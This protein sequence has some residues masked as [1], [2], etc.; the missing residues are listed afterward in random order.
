MVN[1]NRWYYFKVFKDCLSQFYFVHSWIHCLIYKEMV[2]VIVHLK[3]SK[4]PGMRQWCSLLNYS[5][6][7]IKALTL[8]GGNFIIFTSPW[9]QILPRNSI[10]VARYFDRFSQ[11]LSQRFDFFFYLGFFSWTFTIHSAAEV[12]ED[13]SNYILPFPPASQLLRD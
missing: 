9:Q 3:L 10:C 12:G 6:R 11:D 1:L 7:Y 5:Y 2:V 8:L 4:I 13:I